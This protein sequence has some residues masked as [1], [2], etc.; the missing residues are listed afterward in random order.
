V[1]EGGFLTVPGTRLKVGTRTQLTGE[2]QI[3]D[4]EGRLCAHKVF[5]EG[6]GV[7]VADIELG[8]RPPRASIPERFWLP[9]KM[10]LGR[11]LWHHQNACGKSVYKWA[12]RTGRL[13]PYDFGKNSP[14]KPQV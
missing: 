2:T 6:A 8:R 3:V 12:K 1:L 9:P 7:I 13:K 14:E 5:S 10:G 11:L 4:G